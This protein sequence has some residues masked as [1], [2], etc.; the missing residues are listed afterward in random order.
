MTKDNESIDPKNT[1]KCLDVPCQRKE[2]RQGHRKK[3]K[4][5]TLY[6]FIKKELENI[7]VCCSH[8]RCKV[9]TSEDSMKAV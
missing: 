1:V 2:W 6:K 8:G 7:L 3:I 4:I 5:Q 9:A